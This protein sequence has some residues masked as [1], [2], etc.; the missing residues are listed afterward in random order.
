MRGDK[1]RSRIAGLIFLGI[2]L[3]AGSALAQD[4]LNRLKDETLAYFAP[5]KGKILSVKGSLITSDLGTKSGIK[6]GMRFTVLRVGEPFFHPVTKEP[7]GKMEALVGSAVVKDAG[8]DNSTLTVITGDVKAGDILQISETKVR[9]F[10][11]QDKS[12]EWGLGEHYYRL[13]KE[14]N[15]VE[16]IDTA[17]DSGEDSAILSDA[18]QKGAQIALILRADES[19]GDTFVRQRLFWVDDSSKIADSAVK[20]D[21]TFQK[22]VSLADS[23]YAPFASAGDAMLFFDLPFSGRLVAS[24]DVNGDGKLEMILTSGRYV[25]VYAPGQSLQN[26]YEIKGNASDDFLWIDTLDI[27]GDGKDEIIVTSLQGGRDIV[28]YVYGLKDAG[29]AVLWKSNLFLRRLDDGLIAQEF[30]RGEGFSGPVY[31]I[32]YEKGQFKKGSPLKLPKGVN[33][34]DFAVIDGPD[35]MKY[36]LAYNENGMLNLYNPEGL[37]VW[38]NSEPSTGFET[39]FKK[40]APTIMVD[41]GVWTVKDRLLSRNREVFAVK[42]VP[43]ANVAR[44][45]GYKSSQIKSLFWTGLS[46]DERVLVD[47][48]SGSVLDYAIAGDLLVVLSKPLFGIKPMN[49]LKGESPMGTM[50]YVYSLKGR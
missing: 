37:K 2:V 16:F 42:R 50:L 8:P 22:E 6:A 36:T 5:M 47:S 38:N 24:G 15:R 45:L 13:L 28:S 19:G 27:D 4:P 33:I 43:L 44:G 48:I 3:F 31:R 20:V 10:F 34:Y 26:L 35:G 46:M 21:K 23:R 12:V 14:S 30:E 25:R 40:E 41:R 7:L 49:I 18:K 32:I 9:V 39:S 1:V 11:Y 17:L 29:F